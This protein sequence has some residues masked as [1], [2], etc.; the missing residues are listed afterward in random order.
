MTR[1]WLRRVA[2]L[3]SRRGPRRAA[4]ILTHCA[5]LAEL[6]GNPARPLGA[7]VGLAVPIAGR[8][9]SPEELLAR[10]DAAMYG[11][12]R[13]GGARVGLGERQPGGARASS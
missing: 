11:A 1:L 12:K 4:T 6:S 10:A 13:R 5:A 7:S 3:P 9:E 2:V 8:R